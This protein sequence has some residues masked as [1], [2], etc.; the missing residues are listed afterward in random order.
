MDEYVE[1]NGE[2]WRNATTDSAD[3]P[4]LLT[5]ALA[6]Y[7]DPAAADSLMKIQKELDETKIIL[8]RASACMARERFSQIADFDFDYVTR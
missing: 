8:V 1:A 4:Q 6:K 2:A 5:D 7:Q 3:V